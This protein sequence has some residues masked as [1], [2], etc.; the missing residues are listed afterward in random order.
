[1]ARNDPFMDLL[2]AINPFIGDLHPVN[3]FIKFQELSLELRY[4]VYEAYFRSESDCEH[5]KSVAMNRSSETKPAPMWPDL[6]LDYQW[7]TAQI[8][9]MKPPLPFF[10]SICLVNKSMGREAAVCLLSTA[11]VRIKCLRAQRIFTDII[12]RFL[13]QWVFTL[14]LIIDSN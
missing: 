14:H 5:P 9:A 2:Q 4:L 12:R 7:S 6:R 10:P 1:M 3:F 8:A 11:R 13:P